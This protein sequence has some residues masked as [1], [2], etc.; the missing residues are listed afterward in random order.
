LALRLLHSWIA[1]A[2]VTAT[3]RHLLALTL[4]LATPDIVRAQ[5]SPVGNEFRINTYTTG[6]QRLRSM[7]PSGDAF[8]V[9][10]ESD[11]QDGSGSGV[12]AQ[13]M[14]WSP[15][16]PS[17]LGGE[18]RV[19]SYTTSDQSFPR[20][21]ADGVGNFLVVWQ[22]DGQDGDSRGIYA[23][24]YSGTGS[25]LGGELRVNTFTT[26]AQ[27]FPSV[28]LTLSGEFVVVWQSAGQDGS[29]YGVFGQRYAHTGAPMGPEFRVNT[30]TTGPQRF[31]AVDAT[32][33][34][35]VVAREG[36]SANDQGLGI[37]AQRYS[38]SGAPVGG[39][40]R[41]NSYTTGDQR[42]PAVDELAGQV[43][44][45][46]QSTGQDGDGQGVFA[47]RYDGPNWLPQGGEFQVNTFTAQNQASPDVMVGSGRFFIIW[48]SDL[49]DGSDSGVFTRIYFSG[50]P[51]GPEFRMNTY[52]N[53]AQTGPLVID[54]VPMHFTFAWTSA[55]DPDG[56]AGIYAQHWADIPVELQTF[57]VE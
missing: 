52:T 15:S 20:V 54:N 44:I 39:E 4:V 2:S 40:F 23:Q 35:F 1:R 12:F 55:H 6:S 19:N 31:A 41:V 21:A 8:V 43:A 14:T 28:A 9:T 7:A 33:S 45:V 16:P 32:S 36:Y 42:Y 24:R 30:Y 46:W 48:Q 50:F 38:I 22:S 34:G 57:V 29:D 13:R 53:G 25:P 3:S 47:Q 26:L 56:S 18:F 37:F 11:G 5:G 10:W 17:P 51:T 49:Q 27:G